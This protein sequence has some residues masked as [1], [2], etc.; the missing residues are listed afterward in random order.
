VQVSGNEA[1]RLNHCGM[2]SCHYH[3]HEEHSVRHPYCW[4]GN[5]EEG[6]LLASVVLGGRVRKRQ[7]EGRGENE[8]ACNEDVQALFSSDDFRPLRALQPS[9]TSLTVK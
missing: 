8:A 7:D 6:S 9:K 4:D 1:R 2:R 5:D 3:R